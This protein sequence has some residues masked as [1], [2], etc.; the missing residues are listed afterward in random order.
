MAATPS[1]NFSALRVAGG[2]AVV[3]ALWILLS[4]QGLKLIAQD[5]QTLSRLQTW[6]GLFFITITALLVFI[7]LRAEFERRRRSEQR[8]RESEAHLR[9]VFESRLVGMLF[10]HADGRILD[11][12]DAFLDMI[13]RTRADIEGGKLSWASITPR[14]YEGTDRVKLDEVLRSGTAQP[15]EKEYLTKDGRRIP[16]MVGGALLAGQPQMGVSFVVDLSRTR[17]LE[18]QLRQSQKMEAIGQL[19]GGMAHDFNN[20]LTAIQGYGELGLESTHEAPVRV[21]LEEIL[22]AARRASMLTQKL[23]AFSRRQVMEPR[24]LDL[25]EIVRD[26]SGM[27][28]RLLGETVKLETRLAPAAVRVRADQS[29]LEQVVTNLV[30]NARDAMPSGGT[31]TIET[32]R[33]AALDAS[34]VASGPPPGDWAT[35]AVRD[36]GTGMD[37]ATQAHIFEPFFTTKERGRGTGLGLP[38]VYGIVTQSGGHVE[39]QSALG[40][41]ST[42]RVFL[43]RVADS[44]RAERAARVAPSA[45]RGHEVVLLIEDEDSVRELLRVALTA[46]GYTVLPARDGDEA[47]RIADRWHEPVDLLLTDVVMPGIG[48]RQVARR[49]RERWP[50]MPVLYISGYEKEVVAAEVQPG[51]C[52]AL[53]PKPFTP[54]ALAREVRSLLSSCAEAQSRRA[55]EPADPP[56]A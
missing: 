11:A 8:V 54:A 25:N 38:M 16:V 19:A 21:A 52:E 6:K 3:A 23:L 15:F 50:G 7:L 28:E 46:Q 43:P 27:F 42:F 40:R 56:V 48:G 36:T 22:K 33:V 41:G 12:N 51:P 31:L 2:Y 49:L 13:G 20:V 30:V 14:E 1:S 47:L 37:A 44:P 17:Q 55:E 35:L 26:L 5:A 24:E 39:V 10:W 18:H 32:A 53:L 4:D 29:Q 9:S 34:P 45:P